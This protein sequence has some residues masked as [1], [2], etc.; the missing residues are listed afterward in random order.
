MLSTL[1]PAFVLL[2]SMAAITGLVYPALITGVAQ[3]AMPGP[4]NGSL[5][6]NGDTV[7][8]SALIAQDFA[9]PGYLHPRPS[10][11]GKGFDAA[12]SGASNFAPGSKDLHDAVAARVDAVQADGIA[13]PIAPDLVTTSASGLDPDLSPAAALAQAPRIA[14]ARGV[15]VAT[16]TGLID[17]QTS[18]ALLGFIGEPLVNVLLFN[19]QLDR[20]APTPKP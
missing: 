16:V 17:S 3:V 8:G 4:A 15:P 5:I 6:R 1:R 11:A 20:I 2:V 18:A 14:T 12:N 9:T 19:R 13:G 7:I 10:A